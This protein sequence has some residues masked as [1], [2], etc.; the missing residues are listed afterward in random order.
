MVCY[1]LDMRWERFSIVVALFGAAAVLGTI[2]GAV[3]ALIAA[4]VVLAGLA[5]E[6]ARHWEELGALR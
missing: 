1:R 5:V 6:V 3:L 2:S 4:V